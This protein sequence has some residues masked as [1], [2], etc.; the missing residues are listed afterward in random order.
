MSGFLRKAKKGLSSSSPILSI[1]SSEPKP[2]PNSQ[3]DIDVSS[4][5]LDSPTKKEKGKC[6]ITE[7]EIL[8]NLFSAISKQEKSFLYKPEARL[9]KNRHCDDVLTIQCPNQDIT[10]N[11]P[12]HLEQLEDCTAF[13]LSGN[14]LEGLIPISISKLANLTDLYDC[15]LN[16]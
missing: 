1:S 16:K 2:E 11:L 10:G 5:G 15:Y 13:D 4:P 3:R 8:L 7:K 12:D 14:N 6:F 9:R